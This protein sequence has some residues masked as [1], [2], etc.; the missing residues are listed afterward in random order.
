MYITEIE[1]EKTIVPAYE[2][3][4]ELL[5]NLNDKELIAEHIP[6][7]L[8]K[9]LSALNNLV[10]ETVHVKASSPVHGD[11]EVMWEKE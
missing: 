1:D 4:E 3:I 9:W 5:D 8:E 10:L 6:Y 11:V 2:D 7:Y